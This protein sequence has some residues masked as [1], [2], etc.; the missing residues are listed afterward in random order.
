MAAVAPGAPPD[1]PGGGGDK[2]P[3]DQPRK[4]VHWSSPEKEEEEEEEEQTPEP[5][6]RPPRGSDREERR[7]RSLE[8]KLSAG[9]LSLA[10][11]Q[12][13]KCLRNYEFL[14]HD[15]HECAPTQVP[16]GHSLHLSGE[17]LGSLPGNTAA[18]AVFAKGTGPFARTFPSG[19][20]PKVSVFYNSE[21]A[22]ELRE[23]HDN[24]LV[25]GWVNT[26]FAPQATG[27]AQRPGPPAG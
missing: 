19:P 24:R 4:G 21:H 8:C 26:G 23:H 1:P 18:F 12:G 3:H 9:T 27:S 5:K 15:G 20:L 7:R 6:P 22:R 13:S 10:Q 14:V 2:P 25:L 11:L 16:K 17:Q